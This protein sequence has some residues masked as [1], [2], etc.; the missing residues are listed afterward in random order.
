MAANQS[1]EFNSDLD[2]TL[3][4]E[5]TRAQKFSNLNITTHCPPPP[6]PPTHTHTHTHTTTHT[7]YVHTTP[8]T[9]T[10]THTVQLAVRGGIEVAAQF[11]YRL[12]PQVCIHFC[13]QYPGPTVKLKTCISIYHSWPKN[14]AEIYAY[15]QLR[16]IKIFPVRIF[17]FPE[18]LS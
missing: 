11:T 2:H 18:M 5:I 13:K 6:P 10:H 14:Y 1:T 17:S 4:L 12:E 3:Q 15:Y 7:T 8:H 9:H 16:K